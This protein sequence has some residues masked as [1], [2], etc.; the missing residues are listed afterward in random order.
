MGAA[1]GKA[2]KKKER[3]VG[4]LPSP[5]FRSPFL[6]LPP[7]SERLEQATGTRVYVALAD[8]LWLWVSNKN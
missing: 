8:I 6:V 7:L 3:G 5:L 1:Q 2:S 4:Q